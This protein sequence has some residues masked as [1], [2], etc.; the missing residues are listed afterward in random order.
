M[1][2]KLLIAFVLFISVLSIGNAAILYKRSYYLESTDRV[3]LKRLT[4]NL[5]QLDKQK[6]IA[7]SE[8]LVTISQSDSGILLILNS[9]FRQAISFLVISL[10]LGLLLIGYLFVKPRLV[11]SYRA[12]KL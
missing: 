11:S 3:D 4:D 12:E 10:L 2:E 1:L 8:R 5:Q 9:K 7:L 6:L